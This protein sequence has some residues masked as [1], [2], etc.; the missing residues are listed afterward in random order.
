[1][2]QLVDLQGNPIL[3][4]DGTPFTYTSRELARTARGIL[5]GF[6]KIPLKVVDVR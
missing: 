1:M 3:T 4:R 5:A 2:F 6:L